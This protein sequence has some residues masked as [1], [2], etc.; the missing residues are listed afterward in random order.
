MKIGNVFVL[1][2]LFMFFS[3]SNSTY[4]QTYS[5]LNDGKYDN[6]F[7]AED[8]S[9]QIEE[10]SK[11]IEKI[12]SY[13]EYDSYTFSFEH[14][15]TASSLLVN[16][17]Y[18]NLRPD[19]S[20][21]EAGFGTA[22][23]IYADN[24]HQILLTCAHVL[25]YEDTIYTYFRELDANG[26]KIIA[27]VSIKKKQQFFIKDGNNRV[28][29]SILEM[30]IINDIALLSGKVYES[31]SNQQKVINYPVGKSK[32]LQWGDFVYIMGYPSG[33]QMLTR[34]IVSKSAGN[35]NVF[36]I[37]AL[38]NKGFSGGIVI[39]VRDGVPNF[40]IVG[41][42]KSASATH[43]NILIPIENNHENTFTVAEEYSGEVYT[44][45][46]K[47]INY[48]ITYATSIEAIID[49]YTRKRTSLNNL[50]YDLDIFFFE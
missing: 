40:E 21:V 2:F 27:E 23:R 41:M 31:S 18:D 9:Q 3:C 8:C 12:H 47:R 37:D 38:F 25:N 49:F 6:G 32:E 16:S 50:G 28:A 7:P 22:T 14:H 42:I 26:D 1:L 15:L 5:S 44:D 45:V 11:S 13:I 39:A 10:M 4:K 24:E 17:N 34:G 35:K 46:D 30:D 36:L 33:V 48:G 19:N 43:K 20:F 29:F